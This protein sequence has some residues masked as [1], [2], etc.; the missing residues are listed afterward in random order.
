MSEP[1]APE[2]K[3]GRSC[4]RVLLRL[5]MVVV[6]L[7]I[8][9]AAAAGFG[10]Y[11]IYAHI[12]GKGAEGA[13]VRV[14]I[15]SGV[16]GKQAGEILTGAGLVEHETLFRLAVRLDTVK[17]PIVQGFYDIPQGY[18]PTE[19]L[20]MLQEGPNVSATGF[21]VTLPEGLT[22]RQAVKELARQH[23]DATQ[24]KDAEAFIRAA[25]NPDLINEL[26]INA[27]T[28]EG[29]LMPD[30]YLF[31]E[32][33]TPEEVVRRM[34]EHFQSEYDALVKEIPAAAQRDK[35]EVVTMASL[36][37]EESRADD[38]RATVAAVIYNRVQKKMPLDFDST[39]QFALDK[40]G[41]R[42]LDSDKQV[43]SPYNTYRN[44]GLPPGPISSP[45]VESLRAAL[46]PAQVDYL[47]FVSNADGKTH[48][49]SATLEEHNKA[50]AKFRREIA[51]QRKEQEAARAAEESGQ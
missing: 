17:K 44:A 10:A 30:T 3:K 51:I 5:F 36:V 28:L 7:A 4:A 27:P 21:K 16:T 46:E 34:V 22:I 50:V 15:P 26:G 48:T 1:A 18:S 24:F 35:L 31:D 13:P 8:L 23:P 39:L 38:E 49:F 32:E 6:V 25:S 40:Y 47:F 9:A 20:H 33:P 29:F 14:E 41:Q 42:L 43:D 19:I 2:K 11:L 37:E 45:G 12:T